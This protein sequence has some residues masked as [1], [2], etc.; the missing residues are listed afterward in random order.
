MALF[1][2]MRENTKVVLWITVVAFVGLIFLAWGADF[3]SRRG[4]GAGRGEAGVMA[5]VN[6]QRI[7]WTEYRDAWQQAWSGYEQ[8]T[9]QRPDPTV[10]VNMQAR[11]WDN[12][13]VQALLRQEAKRHNIT[14]SDRE[15]A[16]ALVNNPPARFQANPAF[17]TDGQFDIQKYQAWVASPQTNTLPLEIEQRD[18]VTTEKLQLLLFSE[19]KVSEEEAREAW[20]AESQ[21]CALDYAEIKLYQLRQGEQASDSELE[22]YLTSHAD[23]FAIPERVVLEHVRLPKR[24]SETD[25]LDALA[26]INDARGELAR[27]EEFDLL[28]LAYSEASPNRRGGEAA[29]Y[30][31]RN[32]IMPG[33]VADAAFSLP[34][35]EVGDLIISTQGYHVIKVEERIEEEGTEKVKLAEI[36][37]PMRMSAD[38]NVQLRDQMI[39]LADS[40]R[41]LGF[42][43]AAQTAGLQV[44]R[45]SPFARIAFV[46]GLTRIAAAKEFVK[47]ARTGDISKPIETSDG[48]LLLH[49]A[50]VQPAHAGTLEEVRAR[51]ETV[52][53]QERRKETA[54]QMATALLNRVQQGATLAEAAE[55]ESLATF[56]SA[57]DVRRRGVVRGLGAT[58]EITGAA[59]AH[60][61]GLLP[62]VVVTEQGAYVIEVKSLSEI[63]EG[64]YAASREQHYTRILRQKQNRV[65]NDWME[66]LREE[67]M[68]E[69]FRLSVASL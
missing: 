22:G 59:F 1:E 35:G 66:R 46:P 53:L 8:Q 48:W 17:A 6:G 20:L 5:K 62:Y 50:Q 4:S 25:S 38:T 3:T 36:F 39:D 43:E 7:Y 40:T 37:V 52:Y 10:E 42:E 60:G 28:V 12:L 55:A 61:P 30:L 31:T 64:A 44:N 65:L 63:D 2:T 34:V 24:L 18:V 57:E 41:T 13:I 47:S 21:T 51:L 56:A 11:V 68:I 15:V 67:A 32:Q 29:T 9:G 26:E 33:E 69:D 58:P 16:F 19:V 27:G 54:R 45:T 23:D 49:L 14:V